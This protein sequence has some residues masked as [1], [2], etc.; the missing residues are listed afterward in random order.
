MKWHARADGASV[1]LLCNS[2]LQAATGRGGGV[3]KPSE[4]N[5]AV[6]GMLIQLLLLVM[7]LR[8]FYPALC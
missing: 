4:M 3:G 7:Q 2:F 5:K 8:C 6:P 1:L